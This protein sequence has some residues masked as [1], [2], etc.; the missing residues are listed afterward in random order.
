M[1]ILIHAAMTAAIAAESGVPSEI[2]YLPEGEHDITPTVNGKAQ[3]IKVRVPADKGEAI[4]AKLQAAL[5]DRQKQNVRPW[6]DFEHKGGKAAALPTAFRYEPG[7]GIMASIEW[8]GA[9]K[10][11]IEGKDFSYLSPTFLIDAAGL[12]SGL[13]ERGPLAALVNEPAFR[14]IPRIAAKD[15]ADTSP[16]PTKKMDLILAH[17]GID[18]GAADAESAALAKIQAAEA[19][20]ASLKAKNDEL[21]KAAEVATKARHTALVEAA[22]AAGKIAPKDEELKASVLE[23]LAANESLGTKALDLLPVKFAAFEKPL[24]NASESAGKGDNQSR[25][26]AAQA[27]ARAE[28]GQDADFQLVWARAAEIDPDAFN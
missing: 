19:E 18:T 2:V 14:E 6:F 15:A 8:T 7:K 24:V 17:L 13:P 22:V 1:F 26:Q 12:P 21:V 3:R 23:V 4:A 20:L 27:K 16:N 10:A 9:G 11:A 5:A 25:V 28:L